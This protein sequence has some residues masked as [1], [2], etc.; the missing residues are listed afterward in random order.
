VFLEGIAPQ[1]L[2]GSATAI[3]GIHF[4]EIRILAAQ[5]TPFDP[6]RRHPGVILLLYAF[7]SYVHSSID[8]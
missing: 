3:Q 5:V 2:K 1:G 8:L 7:I 4:G 6:V